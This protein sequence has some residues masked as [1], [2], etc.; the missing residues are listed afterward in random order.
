MS[1]DDED[2]IVLIPKAR[3]R[4]SLEECVSAYRIA[5]AA[6]QHAA[7]LVETPHVCRESPIGRVWVPTPKEL[8]QAWVELHCRDFVNW[9][10]RE[11]II[12]MTSSQLWVTQY[13][14]DL[15]KGAAYAETFVRMLRQHGIKARVLS[16]RD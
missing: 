5:H 2:C 13:G 9:A 1:G 4:K 6:A 3:A 7:S 14:N 16:R 12:P 15:D 11:H 10:R 8:G